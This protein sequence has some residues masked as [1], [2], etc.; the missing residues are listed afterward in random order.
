LLGSKIFFSESLLDIEFYA[1]FKKN[2]FLLYK[3]YFSKKERENEYIGRV[4]RLEMYQIKYIF[5]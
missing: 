4:N 2:T 3:V 5:F 1:V